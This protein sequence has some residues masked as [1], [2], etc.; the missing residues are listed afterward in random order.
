M[1]YYTIIVAFDMTYLRNASIFPDEP[2]S[3]P[4]E[5]LC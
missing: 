4:R 1:R 3:T 5:V 2:G